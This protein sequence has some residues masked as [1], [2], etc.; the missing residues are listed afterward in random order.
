[1]SDCASNMNWKF[2]RMLIFVIVAFRPIRCDSPVPCGISHIVLDVVAGPALVMARNCP[3]ATSV[4][5][6]SVVS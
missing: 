1:M 5:V 4:V 2:R 3:V 6:V